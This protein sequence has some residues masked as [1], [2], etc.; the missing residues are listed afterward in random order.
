MV[1]LMPPE[2]KPCPVDAGIAGIG[3]APTLEWFRRNFQEDPRAWLP[4][5]LPQKALDAI[6]RQFGPD[7]LPPPKPPFPLP[8]AAVSVAAALTE[9]IEQAGDTSVGLPIQ[10]TIVQAGTIEKL[11]LTASLKNDLSQFVDVTPTGAE[12]LYPLGAPRRTKRDKRRSQ[13]VR[14]FR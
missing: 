7:S 13:A 6:V 12:K 14:L 3:H 1:Q 9:G 5:P 11:S 4:K 8:S 2:Y 10:V